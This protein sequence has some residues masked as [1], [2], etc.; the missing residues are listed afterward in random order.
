L[1]DGDFL[2]KINTGFI[3]ACASAQSTRPAF[4]FNCSSPISV[5]LNTFACVPRWLAQQFRRMIE[6]YKM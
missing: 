3:G 4:L 5:Q 6:S 1:I 2:I